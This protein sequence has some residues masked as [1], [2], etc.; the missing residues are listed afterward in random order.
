MFKR[1]APLSRLAKVGAFFYPKGGWT[2]ASSYV[3]HRLRRLPDS[4]HRIARGIAAGVFAS[5]TPLFGFHFLLA[6][7][8]AWMIRGNI[9]A[10]L[11][12]TFFGNP[13]TFPIIAAVSLELGTMMLSGPDT[14]PATEAKLI[15]AFADGFSELWRVIGA[16]LAGDPVDLRRLSIFF[17]NLFLPYLVGGFLPGVATAV[18]FYF[19]SQP[20]IM[21][22]Q[23]RRREKFLRRVEQRLADAA[24]DYDHPPKP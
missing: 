6:A 17:N 3:F 2:R 18:V 23:K 8:V 7:A 15:R 9:L 13:I 5:F 11:I 10:A 1:R 20:F 21:A 4:S 16:F 19:I 24:R 22:Y 12:A 14:L